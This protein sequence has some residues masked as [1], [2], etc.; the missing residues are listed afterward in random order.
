[1][2]EGL[3]SGSFLVPEGV[4]LSL[5]KVLGSLRVLGGP[6]GF[7]ELVLAPPGGCGIPVPLPPEIVTQCR[8]P[9]NS[10]E[11]LCLPHSWSLIPITL[12][13]EL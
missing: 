3:L 9:H 7:W 2:F 4:L 12:P 8:T 11:C 5:G 10:T 13:R 6:L 1:M